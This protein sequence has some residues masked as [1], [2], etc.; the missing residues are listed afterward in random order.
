MM[1]LPEQIKTEVGEYS[2]IGSKSV[3]SSVDEE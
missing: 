2:K 1:L 3:C